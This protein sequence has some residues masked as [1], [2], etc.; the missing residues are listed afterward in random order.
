[1][2]TDNAREL[3]QLR[4]EVIRLTN[5]LAHSHQNHPT[6]NDPDHVASRSNAGIYHMVRRIGQQLSNR[7]HQNEASFHNVYEDNKVEILTEIAGT[8]TSVRL[9]INGRLQQVYFAQEATKHN[10]HRLNAGRWITY[11]QTLDKTARDMEEKQKTRQQQERAEQD[12]ERYALV[13]DLTLFA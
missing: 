9:K 11:L 8:L 4:A 6:T 13:D 1:M 2:P 3:A 7:V 10:P 12:P 5:L